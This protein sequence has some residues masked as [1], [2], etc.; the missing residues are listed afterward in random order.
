MSLIM[1]KY[2]GFLSTNQRAAIIA[3]HR[4]ER[5]A[6]QADRLKALVLLDDGYTFDQTAKI[7]HLDDQTIRNYLSKY[8]GGGTEGLLSDKYTG[9]SGCLT[10][11]EENK[12][13]AHLEEFTYPEVNP[14]NHSLCRIYIWE[15]IFPKRNARFTAQT[16][17]HIQKTSNV[18]GKADSDKQ[19]KFID[20]F[21]EFMKNKSPDIPVL[22]MDATHPQYNS[23]PAYGWI[24]K[25]ERKEIQSNTGRE[26][27]NINGV[28][29]AETREAVFVE[30]G[31]INTES[32]ILLL[33]KVEE[34]Y[35]S[36]PHIYVFSD[37][38]RYYHSEKVKEYLKT[39]RILLEK[40][41]PYSPNLNPIERLWKFFH[42]QIHYNK[43]YET[44]SEF[45]LECLMFF[46]RLE[47]YAE[48][49]ASLITLNSK[50]LDGINSKMK[51]IS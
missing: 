43:Y 20:G 16:S 41:P 31:M 29:N 13:A 25:G 46:E 19:K 24:K 45:R 48:K 12:L 37:N 7:L 32:T 11:D 28:L 6:S 35:P 27:L 38:A 44:F 49:L 5:N 8:K 26:R 3:V 18:P 33:K 40:I 51:S 39:S 42:K 17:F 34:H 36:A 10:Q 14:I 21:K 2:K 50:V 30:A 1:P 9:Y 22:F 15:R 4:Y 47:E 23:M